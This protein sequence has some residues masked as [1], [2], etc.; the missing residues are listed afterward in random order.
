MNQQVQQSSNAAAFRICSR[1]LLA[2]NVVLT[3][4][5]TFQIVRSRNGLCRMFA[6]FDCALPS[7][8]VVVLTWWYAWILP[9]LLAFGIA[10]EWLPGSGRATL[11]FDGVHFAVIIVLWQLYIVGAMDPLFRVMYVLGR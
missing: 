5:I 3:A 2:V 10:K 4:F 9:L 7:L 11:I 1:L 6:D 8:S